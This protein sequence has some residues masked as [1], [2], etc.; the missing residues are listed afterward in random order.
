MRQRTQPPAWAPTRRMFLQVAGFGAAGL[1]LSS[2]SND[3]GS[4][5]GSSA[6]GALGADF[7]ESPLD[8]EEVLAQPVPADQV[9][10]TEDEFTAPIDEAFDPPIALTT[11]MSTQPAVVFPAGDS[12]DDNAW[13]RAY[14]RKYGIQV[15]T[16][17]AVDATQ[18]DERVNLMIAS[19]DL[20]DFFVASPA[21]FDQLVKADLV[22]DMTEVYQEHASDLVK[23]VILESGPVPLQSAVYDGR[24]MGV[25]WSSNNSENASV[26]GIRKD[27]LDTLGLPVPETMDDLLQTA[28]AFVTEDP[29]GNGAGNTFG[30]SLDQLF[31]L[32]WGFFNGF[33]AYKETWI[34]RDGELVYGSIQ[35]EM[36][37]ALEELQRMHA[38][39]L[40]DPEFGSKDGLKVTEDIVS[41]RIGIFQGNGFFSTG[42]PIKQN[43]P[44][45][46]IVAIPLV[47]VDDS[48]ARP[49]VIQPNVRGYWVV[50]KGYEHP[51][52]IFRLLEFFIDA[53]YLAPSDEIYKVFNNDNEL[54]S[55]VWLL[56][57][58][59][60]YRAYKN[61]DLYLQAT[62]LVDSPNPD[63]AAVRPEPRSIYDQVTQYLDGG[64]VTYYD[65]YL[66]F[67]GPTSG[68]AAE[69]VYR[70]DNRY[71]HG[72]FYGQ[73]TRTMSQ[74]QAS[75]LT[76][77]N[78]TFTNIIRG[79]SI[80]EFDAFV[81]EWL[82][83]G[84]DQITD[85][86]NDWHAEQEG[87]G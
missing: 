66:G 30:I 13:T 85:E 41:G 75:L 22:E 45:A 71:M 82:R 35:P 62:E 83:I 50:R 65:F 36:R 42:T 43:F 63:L 69:D 18:F 40:I 68:R 58:A 46:E 33:H 80:D 17:W 29:G 74:R 84:G 38:A 55:P 47:S 79:A 86:V 7:F 52:A 49:Q 1:V 3:N 39:G 26:W 8:L 73:P 61:V 70:R 15:T 5:N 32:T 11:V 76:Q 6:G 12:Q 77:E 23:S 2:C 54:D 25:P 24:L 4:D 51:E 14:E 60:V 10:M 19:G 44:D 72:A 34:E 37:D 9:N 31:F 59:A 20:P 81:D 78:E 28:E 48:P 53:F 27:W 64:D 21:Q 67:Y 16:E 87:T 57:R 56:N